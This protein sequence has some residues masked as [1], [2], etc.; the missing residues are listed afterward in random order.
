[1]FPIKQVMLFNE[2]TN[3]KFSPD[4]RHQTT[5][6]G[7]STEFRYYGSGLTMT[8]TRYESSSMFKNTISYRAVIVNNGGLKN[9]SKSYKNNGI[10]ARKLFQHYSDREI[11]IRTPMFPLLNR[12]R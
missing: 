6:N 9:V 11:M 2:I 1:M 7:A 8:I 4:K 10:F 12:S 3:M 5:N